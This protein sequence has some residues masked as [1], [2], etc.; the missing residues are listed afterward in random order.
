M[1]V[2]WVGVLRVC[3]GVCVCV[4]VVGVGKFCFGVVGLKVILVGG[5]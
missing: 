5:D 1:C 2:G 3:D 4:C